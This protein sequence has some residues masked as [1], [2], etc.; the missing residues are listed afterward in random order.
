M[1]RMWSRSRRLRLEAVSRSIKASASVSPR[2]DWRTP[3]S[4]SWTRG[5]LFCYRSQ[6]SCTSLAKINDKF[7]TTF[8]LRVAPF[9][10]SPSVISTCVVRFI[11]HTYII[12]FTVY[13]YTKTLT[14]WTLRL[15][16][17]L[18]EGKKKRIKWKSRSW[19]RSRKEL[20]WVLVSVSGSRPRA[21]PCPAHWIFESAT[22]LCL[23]TWSL[24]RK[25]DNRL[26]PQ[27][28]RLNAVT[29]L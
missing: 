26:Q 25:G 18:Q 27:G 11:T 1:P 7:G 10:D 14:W 24:Q 28:C 6:T 5:S 22:I 15:G 4:Q 19:L 16:G 9:D 3:R 13:H 21:H 23:P 20:Y 29:S 17:Y 12:Y 2:T 8:F